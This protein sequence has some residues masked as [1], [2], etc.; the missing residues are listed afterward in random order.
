[1]FV[2]VMVELESIENIQA[3]EVLLVVYNIIESISI[4]II[5]DISKRFETYFNKLEWYE[6]LPFK[7]KHTLQTSRQYR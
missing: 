7:E 4:N 2:M 1:M 5:Q 6:T 3:V